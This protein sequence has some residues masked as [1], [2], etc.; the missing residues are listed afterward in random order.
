MGGTR[1][2]GG[3]GAGVGSPPVPE[4]YVRSNRS[5]GNIEIT[6]RVSERLLSEETEKVFNQLKKDLSTEGV[7]SVRTSASDMVRG[8]SVVTQDGL[9]VTFGRDWQKEGYQMREAR[10]REKEARKNGRQGSFRWDY[11][12]EIMVQASTNMF[13]EISNRKVEGW[14][15]TVKKLGRDL[16]LIVTEERP[17]SLVMK[18]RR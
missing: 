4:S 10:A 13:N 17:D 18:L 6:E 3:S 8:Y 2:S 1:S 11:P 7:P 12:T 14:I 9:R 16:G 5:F 15:S